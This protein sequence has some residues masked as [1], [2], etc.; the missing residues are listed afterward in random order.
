MIYTPKCCSIVKAQDVVELGCRLP[1]HTR[2]VDRHTI[3]LIGIAI[4]NGRLKQWNPYRTIFFHHLAQMVCGAKIQTFSHK[5]YQHCNKWMNDCNKRSGADPKSPPR[6]QQNNNNATVLL[7]DEVTSV[8]GQ[9]EVE[10]IGVSDGI[11]ADVVLCVSLTV[12]AQHD[13]TH[14]SRSVSMVGD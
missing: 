1:Y 4:E 2:V 14:I 3:L 12:V 11:E 6:T 10:I 7:K 9:M 5:A 13:T 8:N